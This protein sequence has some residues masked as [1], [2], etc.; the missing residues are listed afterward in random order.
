ML[1]LLDCFQHGQDQGTWDS[2]APKSQQNRD[3]S[4]PIITTPRIIGHDDCLAPLGLDKVIQQA[5]IHAHFNWAHALMASEVVTG[6]CLAAFTIPHGLFSDQFEVSVA[7]DFAHTNGAVFL[8]IDV[9]RSCQRASC[10]TYSRDSYTFHHERL[11][12][13]EAQSWTMQRH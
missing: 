8:G 4:N 6:Q 2:E 12:T 3:V 5:L 10:V 11:S 1:H 7:V 13:D 9:A